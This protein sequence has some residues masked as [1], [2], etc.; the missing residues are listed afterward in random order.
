MP[1]N[2]ISRIFVGS[3]HP[4]SWMKRSEKGVEQRADCEFDR[5]PGEEGAELGPF[6]CSLAWVAGASELY[7]SLRLTQLLVTLLLRGFFH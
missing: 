2:E 7:M 1:S 5:H 3:V 4:T 6:D